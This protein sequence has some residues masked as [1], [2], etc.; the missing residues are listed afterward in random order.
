MANFKLIAQPGQLGSTITCLIDAPRERVFKAYTEAA[1][2]ARWWGPAKYATIVDKLEAKPG[3]V[4]RFINRSDSGEE[5][6]FHGVYH[7]IVMPERI[8]G[9]FEFEGVPGHVSLETTTLED[10][11]GKTWI[12][13]Q[14]VFQSVE[15]RDGMIQADM[16]SGARESYERLE[17]LAAGI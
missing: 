14:A 5:F 2:I 6:A 11:G 8:V 12:T 17:A 3:G 7:A 4:W 10:R 13:N 16:E 9:T 1:L 15:D